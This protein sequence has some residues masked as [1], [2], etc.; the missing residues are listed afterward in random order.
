MKAAPRTLYGWMAGG[1]VVA[2]AAVL[3]QEQFF[4][5]RPDPRL[6]TKITLGVELAA[7]DEVRIGDVA[8]RRGE[9]DRWEIL[10]DDGFPADGSKIGRLLD[11]LD[12]TTLQSRVGDGA[13]AADEFGLTHGT[14]IELR[15]K[16]KILL[17]VTVG[18]SRPGGGQYIGLGSEPIVYLVGQ[19]IAARADASE[20]EL[21]TLVDEP[22]KS[23]RRI[24]FLKGGSRSDGY[25][26][27]RSK[28]EDDLAWVG[29]GAPEEARRGEIRDLERVLERLTFE[30]RLDPKNAEVQA[31]LHSARDWSEV[32]V[33]LFNGVAYTLRTGTI[34]KDAQQKTFLQVKVSIEGATASPDEL[35]RAGETAKIAGKWAFRV[36]TWNI[37][38]LSKSRRE[39]VGGHKG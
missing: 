6:G 36:P 17:S 26:V 10:G 4:A 33:V 5:P 35:D 30:E 32:R 9:K 7:L 25:E 28:P 11:Q 22:P 29:P 8:L 15:T 38:K 39:W 27:E 24:E 13:G 21:R 19:N 18:E 34:G 16:D 12:T 23:V 20:W 3:I 37:S 1:L 2:A 31:A 14:A